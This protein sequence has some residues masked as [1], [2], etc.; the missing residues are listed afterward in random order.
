MPIFSKFFKIKKKY[1]LFFL[2]ILI[3][4]FYFQFHHWLTLERLKDSF[5][6]LKSIYADHPKSFSLT[7]FFLYILITAISLPG[8]TIMTIAAGA[9]FDF[10]WGLVLVSFGSTLGATL[11]FWSARTFFREFLEKKYEKQLIKINF[12]LGKDGIYYLFIL[13]LIPLF[14]YFMINL[15]L[16][17]TRMKTWTFYWCSQ[18]G[19]LLGAMIYINAGKQLSS[20]NSLNDVMSWRVLTAIFL[21]GFIPLITLLVQKKNHKNSS[22]KPGG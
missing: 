21:I 16:G 12:E 4:G 10:F 8:A 22:A 14:P 3:L 19:M 1:V 7:Y 15:L 9:L 20:L 5:N 6:D 2:I 18:V 17:L 13:R 11:A